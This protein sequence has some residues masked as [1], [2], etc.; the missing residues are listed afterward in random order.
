M[1]SK[2]ATLTASDPFVIVGAGMAGAMAAR[3]L[4]EQGF[5]GPSCCCGD[6]EA[7]RFDMLE[8]S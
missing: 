3:T 6:R 2:R 8:F 7:G 5:D 1:Q 4:R